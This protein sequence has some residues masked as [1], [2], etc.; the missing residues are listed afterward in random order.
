MACS[1]AARHCHSHHGLSHAWNRR[2]QNQKQDINSPQPQKGK[3]TT[4]PDRQP[5]THRFGRAACLHQRGSNMI[6]T[7][8][9]S[10]LLAE[11]SNDCSPHTH[12]TTLRSVSVWQPART[13]WWETDFP[14]KCSWAATHFWL[15]Q[16]HT[17]TLLLLIPAPFPLRSER[18]EEWKRPWDPF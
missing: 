13:Q 8:P 10:V 7:Q 12:Y 14:I 1:P 11:T 6:W 4:S 15:R 5:D 2:S 3:N 16:T 9:L 18:F 17:N